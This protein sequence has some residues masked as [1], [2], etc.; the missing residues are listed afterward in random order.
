MHMTREQALAAHQR[1]I[2]RGDTHRQAVTRARLYIA[3][4]D[5]LRKE[6]SDGRD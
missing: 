6:L 2:E 3:T 5:Q 1:A 4:H